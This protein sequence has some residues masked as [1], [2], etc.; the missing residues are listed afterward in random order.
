ML[1]F[2]IYLNSATILVPDKF[3]AWPIAILAFVIIVRYFKLK[4]KPVLETKKLLISIG[5]FLILVLSTAY[6]S[7]IPYALKKLETGS[8]LVVFPLLFYI[9]A[10]D[11]NIFSENTIRTL[12]LTFII[13]LV[14]FLISTFTYFYFTEPFFSFKDTLEHYTNLVDI[15]ISKYRIHPIYLSIYIGIAIIFSF[16]LFKE[17]KPKTKYFI[18]F[19]LPLLIAFTAILNKKGPIISLAVIG[20]FFLIKNKLN[21]KKIV[22]ITTLF[23]LLAGLIVFIPRYKNE[24]KF[25]EL[26]EIGNNKNSSSG[27]RLQI[28]GCALQE[29]AKSPICGYGW[30]DVKTALSN[31]YARGTS[32]ELLKNN[33]NS[34]NQYLSIL[35][36]IGVLGFL[37]FVY[38]LF[39]IFKISRQSNSQALFFLTLY[40]CLN[41]LTENI[42]E[43]ED[44]VIVIAFFLNFFIFKVNKKM[45][46]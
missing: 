12:K 27:L 2:F 1:L 29:I 32:E 3:K 5:F 18:F 13:S 8:S 33:Y 22:Y 4:P 34:H 10:G 41:M 9:I 24:N 35:L 45:K 19:A 39:Y 44:G 16:T 42:L 20:F 6:S 7:D 31:C 25:E 36:S 28:Y 37:A 11:R 46:P 17:N 14:F 23:I 15:R 38:Y 40:F 21:F 30:G 26:L 43:R